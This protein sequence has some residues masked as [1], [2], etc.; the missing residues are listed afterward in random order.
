MI[1]TTLPYAD[2]SAAARLKRTP[3][4]LEGRF[5]ESGLVIPANVSTG[6][7]D[8]FARLVDEVGDEFGQEHLEAVMSAVYSPERVVA[9]TLHDIGREYNGAGGR[10]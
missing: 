5:R 1:R 3:Y 9:M 8:Q 10:N 7:L 4:A 2:I 6:A